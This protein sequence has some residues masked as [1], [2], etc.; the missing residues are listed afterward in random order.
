MKFLGVYSKQIYKRDTGRGKEY[1]FA[2]LFSENMILLESLDDNLSPTGK[3]QGIGEIDFALSHDR[4]LDI[5]IEDQ[6]PPEL[7]REEAAFYFQDVDGSP[8]APL[9]G[10]DSPAARTSPSTSSGPFAWNPPSG[11]AP[12]ANTSGV[13]A[14]SGPLAA[15]TRSR[16]ELSEFFPIHGLGKTGGARACG[17][18]HGP[19]DIL[20][21]NMRND[22][23]LAMEYLDGENK[24]S[25][26][27]QINKILLR[28]GNFLPDHKFMFCEFGQILRRAKLFKQSIVAYRRAL[29]L[30][31][32]S[33]VNLFFNIAR[34]YYELGR[35]KK[36]VTFLEQA[37]QVD[38]HF[39]EAHVFLDF[40]KKQR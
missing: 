10:G 15:D 27:H 32:Y 3:F 20:E 26:I 17:G 29:E 30:S 34:V 1:F 19:N 31:P 38:R 33:D 35:H 2:W 18:G 23:A 4:D 11:N 8:E 21:A 25:A 16:F 5:K 22:L 7:T 37:L 40:I 12:A 24:S 6:A 9:L 28:K 13:N 39:K 14:R 36:A